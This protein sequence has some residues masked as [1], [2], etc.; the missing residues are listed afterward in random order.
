VSF[1]RPDILP[2]AQRH[3]EKYAKKL[4]GEDDVV[5]VLQ[6]LDRLTAEESRV[7][8]A[9]TMEVVHGLVNN[10]KVVMDG[11]QR[12]HFRMLCL[13]FIVLDGK[14]VSDGIRQTL[15]RFGLQVQIGV[16]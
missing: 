3:A 16:F 7:T 13:T 10:M 8:M 14:A 11:A 6:R 1:F 9:Q 2:S 15:S 4:M 12:S 5:A